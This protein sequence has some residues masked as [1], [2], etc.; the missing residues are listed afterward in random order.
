MKSSTTHA[1]DAVKK[2]SIEHDAID[3][4]LALLQ[5]IE[6]QINRADIKA[7][8][9][10]AID[11]LLVTSTIFLNDGM[12]L[13]SAWDRTGFSIDHLI[14]TFS[15]LMFVSLFVSTY[16]AMLATIPKLTSPAQ[17]SHNLFYFGS[18]ASADEQEFIASF[19]EKQPEEVRVLMLSEIHALS[20]IAQRKFIRIRLSHLLLFFALA[21]W[22]IAQLLCVFPH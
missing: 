20:S 5:H 12:L 15:V 13:N 1:L 19:S 17:V 7:E 10:L 2:V 8:L 11:A 9:T 4:G 3:L 14:A 6:G 16:C 18:I 22:G 21:F